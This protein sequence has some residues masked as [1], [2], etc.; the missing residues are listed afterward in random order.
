MADYKEALKADARLVI[1][2]ELSEQTDGRL[3]QTILLAALDRF[4]YRRNIEWLRTQLR[5]LADLEAVNIYEVG[6]VM[7]AEL[8]SQGH[9]H[10]ERRVIIDGIKRPSPPRV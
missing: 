2:K 6:S 7:I 4:G 1:L 5:A 3:N 8:T 9:D 10:L